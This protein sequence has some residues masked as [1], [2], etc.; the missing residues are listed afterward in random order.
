MVAGIILFWRKASEGYPFTDY[1]LI[2]QLQETA[3]T[4]IIQASCGIIYLLFYALF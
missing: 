3:G 4:L 1:S 2:I